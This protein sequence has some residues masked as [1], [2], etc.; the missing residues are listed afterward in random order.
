[1]NR[2]LWFASSLSE[3]QLSTGALPGVGLRFISGALLFCT[4]VIIAQAQTRVPLPEQSPVSSIK[5]PVP[6]P[7]RVGKNTTGK[8]RAEGA[9]V[10]KTQVPAA[11][12][13][14]PGEK[15]LTETGTL[16]E[17]PPPGSFAAAV[18][19]FLNQGQRV[20]LPVRQRKDALWSYYVKNEG[21]PIWLDSARARQLVLRMKRADLDGLRVE[22]YPS[23]QLERLAMHNKLSF[24]V[25]DLRAFQ[26]ALELY[27]SAFF[28]KYASDLKVGRFLPTKVDSKLY[29]HKKRIDMVGALNLVARL[30][31]LGK[32]FDAWQPQI[33]AYGGLKAALGVFK[34]VSAAGGWPFVPHEPILK[35]G[36][37]NPT[38]AHLRAR[39][40]ATDSHVSQPV[41]L[42]LA[43]TYDENLVAAVKRFQRAHGLDDDGVV[44]KR[45]LFQ[46]NIPAEDRVRQLILSMERWR[47]MP[48]NLGRH[49]IMVNIA[50]FQ[51]ERIRNHKRE[52]RMRVVVGTPFHQTPVFSRPMKY[53]ELNPYWNVPVSI[54][55]NE[56]L[57]ELQKNASAREVMGFEAVVDGKA[58]PVTKINWSGYSSANF[59]VRLRQKPGKKN[60]LGR[61][62][63]MFPN[64][65]H[66]YMHDTPARGLFG[67]TERAFSH[68]CIRLARPIDLAE[69]VLSS[70]SQWDRAKIESVLAKEER[71]VVNLKQSIDVHITYSTAWLGEDGRVNFR[72]DLY[73]R[74][75]KLYLALFGKPSPY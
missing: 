5:L 68:G 63:F 2:T 73:G 46:L 21:A 70:E 18:A 36:I 55:I 38:V 7:K 19:D 42:T 69:Q 16:A 74:D 4:S 50:G 52:E 35:P 29:W 34:R 71:T 37:I 56:E 65:F 60:A 43:N 26:V 47:W 17:G 64:P 33:P 58:V 59:P 49:Y 12:A 23:K 9:A 40:A 6:S 11:T 53:V 30:G 8:V 15:A 51:L 61:V 20:V 66:V 41:A 39:L 1:M 57:A 10:S 13:L 32:F 44:G 25:R 62:K 54:A 72:P 31:D 14:S 45:T 24:G 67:R 48:E 27:Y 22:D 28:L 3:M 75:K